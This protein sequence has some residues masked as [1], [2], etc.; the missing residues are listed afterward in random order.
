MTQINQQFLSKLISL[1]QSGLTIKNISQLT[2]I[3]CS[4][5]QRHLSHLPK[6]KYAKYSYNVNVF[7]Q[8]DSP[9]KAY[10]LGFLMADGCLHTNR[11]LSLALKSS[12]K[13]HIEKF[14][15]FMGAN[16][17]INTYHRICKIGQKQFPIEY[18]QLQ[19]SVTQIIPILNKYGIINK[20]TFLESIPEI[21][22]KF[23]NSFILG[24]FDGDGSW[25]QDQDRK[26]HKF[27][28]FKIIGNLDF[29][30]QIQTILVNQLG[31]SKNK[32]FVSNK[33]ERPIYVLKYGGNQNVKKIARY[34]YKD[35]SIF[36]ERKK[37][38][39][40]HLLSD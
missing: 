16:H 30:T 19:M 28:H 25:V 35:C 4:S 6:R 27:V 23:V 7:D 31:L 1:Y 20:K 12:D 22:D 15:T 3:S 26:G 36:L 37:N 14:R 34:L 40:N 8:I 18:S 9:D 21:D 38:L 29:V 24:F 32:I 13:E 39:V 2:N 33:T 17:P 10:W 11:T 5:I